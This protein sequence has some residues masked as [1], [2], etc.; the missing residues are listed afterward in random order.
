M[1]DNPE[2]P[3][4]RSALEFFLGDSDE[5]KSQESWDS[6]YWEEHSLSLKLRLRNFFRRTFHKHLS[7]DQAERHA[8]QVL[9]AQAG[10]S[11]GFNPAHTYRHNKIR[12]CSVCG[13]TYQQAYRNISSPVFDSDE[14]LTIEE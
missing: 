11:L 4:A 9:T 14:K 3:G 7:Y 12:A 13:K 1:G 10:G 5:D 2:I 6:G 8:Q